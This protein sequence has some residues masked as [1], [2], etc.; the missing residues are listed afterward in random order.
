VS[1]IPFCRVS[2]QAKESVLL[3]LVYNT[4]F[5]MP[6]NATDTSMFSEEYESYFGVLGV[7]IDR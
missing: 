2:P 5:T 7:Y 4:F 6:A 1:G 3:S